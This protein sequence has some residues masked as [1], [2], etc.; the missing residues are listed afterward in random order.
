M[1]INRLKLFDGDVMSMMVPYP[2]GSLSQPALFKQVDAG[3]SGDTRV[4][5]GSEHQNLQ[6][7]HYRVPPMQPSSIYV[8]A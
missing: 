2:A 8:L 5:P 3:R 7:E 4:K 1:D 6:S